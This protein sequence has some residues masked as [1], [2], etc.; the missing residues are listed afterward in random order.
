[1]A[2]GDVLGIDECEGEDAGHA[3]QL[4]IAL[5]EAPDAIVGCGDGTADAVLG[6]QVAED[7]IADGVHGELGGNF[8]GGLSTYTIDDE[9]DAVCGVS[10]VAVFV[11]LPEEAGVGGG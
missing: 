4:R 5:S 8:T 10:V 2:D 9:V 3:G 1:M 6:W 11:A 7:G